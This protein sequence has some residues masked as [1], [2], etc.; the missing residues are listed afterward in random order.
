LILEKYRNHSEDKIYLHLFFL[1]F[2]FYCFAVK[3]ITR[4]KTYRGCIR[5]LKILLSVPLN[6]RLANLNHFSGSSSCITGKTKFNRADKGSP[7]K[8]PL[9]TLEHLFFATLCLLFSVIYMTELYI[10]IHSP[11]SLFFV[12]CFCK[13]KK[14]DVHKQS[15]IG[16]IVMLAHLHVVS[17]CFCSEELSTCC[18]DCIA[19]KA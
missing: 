18:R 4:H 2:F 1:L 3:A 11:T 9:T 15:F 7:V 6:Q 5:V 12:A 17:N 13:T 16:A 14:L 8:W 10:S 19:Y